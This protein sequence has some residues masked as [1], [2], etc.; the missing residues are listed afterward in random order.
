MRYILKE[1][2]TV[3]RKKLIEIAQFLRQVD[4]SIY[5]IP[6]VMYRTDSSNKDVINNEYPG[7]K[8]KGVLKVTSVTA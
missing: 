7:F 3:L 1:L 5:E 6:R 2:V 4:K 8:N